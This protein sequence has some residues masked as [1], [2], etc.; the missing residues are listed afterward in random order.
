MPSLGAFV[1]LACVLAA[2]ATTRDDKDASGQ[3][4]SRQ[5]YQET[6]LSVLTGQDEVIWSYMGGFGPG[7][8]K[9]WSHVGSWCR[10]CEAGPLIARGDA[11]QGYVYTDEFGSVRLM[12]TDKGWTLALVSGMFG[13]CG[14]GWSS[15]SFAVKG[16]RPD[17]CVVEVAESRLYSPAADGQGEPN[18]TGTLLKKGQ[19]VETFPAIYE[20]DRYLVARVDLRVGLV[21]R[22]DVK[23]RR[24]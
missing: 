3:Y 18:P 13:W 11:S 10:T 16:R 7:C 24:P 5:R 19:R 17:E 23:C 22:P 2:D 1:C 21:K 9:R 15:D 8:T 4:E 6:T 20:E 14:M 12:H